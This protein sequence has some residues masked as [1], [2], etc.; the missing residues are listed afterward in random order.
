M[1]IDCKARHPPALAEP[2]Q[3]R[4][5]VGQARPEWAVGAAESPRQAGCGSPCPLLLRHLL[6]SALGQLRR[7][8]RLRLQWPK[9]E[10][11]L[12]HR[13]PGSGHNAICD[14]IAAVPD[15]LQA[16]ALM[17]PQLFKRAGASWYGL[18][19]CCLKR[20]HGSMSGANATPRNIEGIVDFAQHSN[21][22]VAAA[23]LLQMTPCGDG[24]SCKSLCCQ[25]VCKA[26]GYVCL[27]PRPH[28]LR[29]R[30][31]K[32]LRW[33]LACG[34]AGGIVGPGFSTWVRHRLGTAA[35]RGAQIGMP[36]LSRR[37]MFRLLD[38]SSRSASSV[39]PPV[40]TWRYMNFGFSA[41]LALLSCASG[42]PSA[43]AQLEKSDLH[44]THSVCQLI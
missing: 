30:V 7:L 42:V 14:Q 8:L 2:I 22:N 1:P 34:A 27:A 28:R 25:A 21:S 32:Q 11:P 4:P 40:V 26:N 15:C 13:T 39:K 3:A 37:M 9:L 24:R 20:P 31:Q 38:C 5:L 6:P 43:L 36:L 19:D 18:D 23:E 12:H 33:K 44:F 16:S 41:C 17:R 35:R 29:L 10:I